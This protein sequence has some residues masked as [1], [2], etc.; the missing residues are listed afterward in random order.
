MRHNLPI[1]LTGPQSSGKL[2]MIEH[3]ASV[4]LKSESSRTD[5]SDSPTVT[6]QL[7]DHSSFD[8][9]SLIGSY[10]SSPR[11]PGTF[12]WVEG[13]LTRA[14]RSGKWLVLKDI[15]KATSEILSV[16]KPLVEALSD[17]KGIGCLP[18]LHLG[19]R[20]KVK[21]GK[22]FRLFATRSAQPT[23]KRHQGSQYPPANFRGSRHWVEVALPPLSDQDIAN[24]SSATFPD[25]ANDGHA[26]QN[27]HRL[28]EIFKSLQASTTVR[29]GKQPLAQNTGRGRYPTLRDLFKWF[30]RIERL[31]EISG[32]GMWSDQRKRDR[33]FVEAVEIF[34]GALP[35]TFSRSENRSDAETWVDSQPQLKALVT[36]FG[37]DSGR[38]YM[39]VFP[40]QSRLASKGK[41]DTLEDINGGSQPTALQVGRIELSRR[42]TQ[43]K[44]YNTSQVSRAFALTEPT[45][46]LLERIAACVS[47]SEPALLVGETGTGKTTTVQH[48]ASLLGHDVVALNLSQQSEASDLLGS[49]KPLEPRGPATELHNIWYDL[50]E[51]T[52]SAKRNANFVDS[53]R[54]ALQNAKWPRLVTLWKESIRMAK[55]R[56]EKK[57]RLAAETVQRYASPEDASLEATK[58]RRT[59]NGQQAT[60]VEQAAESSREAMLDENWSSFAARVSDF[61]A[62]HAS[63]KRNFVFNFVE[64]PLVKALRQGAWVLL[65]EINL[66]ASETLDSLSGMLSTPTASVTLFERGDIEPIPRHPDFRI[67][68]CM[69]PA[70]DVGKKDLPANLRNRFT[71]L[72]V[73]S[74]DS[75][76]AA[77]RAIVEQY[78]GHLATGP[79]NRSAPQDVAQCYVEIRQ[80]AIDR[81]ADGANQRP[82]Y[83]IRTLARAL[84]FAADQAHAFGLRRALWEGFVMAFTMLLQED[85]ATLIRQILTQQLLSRAGNAKQAA[86]TA[87]ARP[88]SR[89]GEDYVRVGPFWLSTGPEPIDMAE[90]Y[91]V[92][93]S[94]DVKLT[95]LARAILARN[96][97]V[98]IQGPTSAGKTSAIE[99]LARRTG[100]RFVRIN[101]HEHTD[102]QEYLGS[103]AS[104]QDTGRLVFH[105]GLLVKALRRGDWIVL[106]ELNLAPTDVLEALNR[107][108]DDNRELIIPETGEVVRPHPRFM[109]FA[110]QNPP[111]IYAGRK[112]LSRAFRNRFLELHFDDVPRREL[113]VI[114]KE[115]CQI[116]ESHAKKIVAVFEELQ[117][118][119]QTDRI[120]DTKQAFVTL[121][122]LF[123]WGQRGAVTY[124]ELA[125][126]GFM[127]IAERAR[128][129]SDRSVVKTVIEET[130]NERGSKRVKLNEHSLYDLRGAGRQAMA[131]R[132]GEERLQAMIT[133]CDEGG[134]VWTAAMSR[135]LCL[136]A[137]SLTHNEPVLLVGETGAGKT[138]ACEIVAKALGRQLYTVNCHQ[139]TETADLIGGQR[140]LRNRG[141]LQA[142]AKASSLA[143][144]RTATELRVDELEAESLD[145]LAAMLNT[146]IA[147]VKEQDHLQRLRDAQKLITQASALFEWRDG[148][149]VEAM[150]SGHHL[151]LDEISL[152]DDSV[153]ERLN[154]VLEPSRTL[155][156]AEKSGASTKSSGSLD[157]A[158]IQGADGFQ[159]VATMNPGGDYGKKELSPALRNRFTEIWV[160]QV[161]DH[162][163]ILAIFAAQWAGGQESLDVLGPK[164]LAFVDWFAIQLG[165]KDQAGTG[166]RDLVAW[167]K[168][169]KTC[170]ATQTLDSA[171][172]FVHGAL[173]AFI[174]GIG[175]MAA[176]TAMSPAGIQALRS[177]CLTK[178]HELAGSHSDS[179]GFY[180]TTPSVH[181]ETSS[182]GIGPF[183][184][185]TGPAS[186]VPS[187]SDFSFG[188]ATP[189]RNAL[190]VLRA[191][192]VPNKAVLLEG[193]PGAGKT[194]L[195]T[196][197][198]QAASYPLT[199][200]NLSDQTELV[201]LFGADLP[202]EGGG[203][204][205]FAWKDAAFLSAMQR[206]EWV[207]LDEMNL[208]S[209]SVLEGLNSCLDHRGSVY[210]PELGRTFEKHPDF[211]LFAAQNPH[212][213]GGG[214]KGLPKSFLNRFT[215]V[216]VDEL[217][218][219]DILAICSH[220]YPSYEPELLKKM[221]DFNARLHLE[222]M[223]KR[224]F[225]HQGAPWEFNLRDLLR[226]LKMIHSHLGLNWKR[227]PMEYLAVLY[228]QR[229]R[230]S[231][232]RAAAG[233]IFESVFDRSYDVNV[234]PWP[235]ITAHHAQFGHALLRRAVSL[236]D[237]STS[238]RMALLPSQL[239]ALEAL[240]D[241][242]QLQWLAILVGPSKCG[243]TSLVRLLARL[244]GAPLEE[245]RMNSGIDTMDVLGTFEQS[246]PGQN[247]RTALDGLLQVF[248]KGAASEALMAGSSRSS[249]FALDLISR[250]L[251]SVTTSQQLLDEVVHAV[252][253]A[254]TT[255]PAHAADQVAHLVNIVKSCSSQEQNAA[256]R[257]EWTDGPLV[258]A[259]REGSWLLVD[260]ANL[261][262]ASVLDRLNSLFEPDGRL[263]LSERG[264][265]DGHI[266]V[267]TPH[268]NFR[269]FMALDPQHGELSRA[270]RN[271]GLEISLSPLGAEDDLDRLE[272]ISSLEHSKVLGHNALP[273]L[274]EY[275]SLTRAQH[276][277]DL[278]SRGIDLD[279][280]VTQ[281]VAGA[282]TSLSVAAL[283]TRLAQG[284]QI[285]T[286]VQLYTLLHQIGAHQ[287]ALKIRREV[288]SEKSID[289]QFLADEAFCLFSNPQL[290]GDDGTQMHEL[291]AGLG[292]VI[293]SLSLSQLLAKVQKS[294][295]PAKGGSILQNWITSRHSPQGGASNDSE[296]DQFQQISALVSFIQALQATA[297]DQAF[298][299]LQRTGLV[300]LGSLLELCRYLVA[301]CADSSS[302]DYSVQETVV[303]RA[304]ELIASLDKADSRLITHWPGLTPQ[305]RALPT[306]HAMIPIWEGS[307]LTPAI[308]DGSKLRTRLLQALQSHDRRTPAP[309]MFEAAIDLIATLDLSNT[310]WT[311]QQQ[312]DF[313]A[314]ASRVEEQLASQNSTYLPHSDEEVQTWDAIYIA[315]LQLNLS[316]HDISND[317]CVQ[318]FF[319][320]LL[321]QISM[322]AIYPWQSAVTC[323]RLS[324]ML[325]AEESHQSLSLA[326]YFQWTQPLASAGHLD[327]LYQSSM[328]QMALFPSSASRISMAALLHHRAKATRMAKLV[329]AQRLTS[330]P[331]RKSNFR[332]ELLTFSAALL[333]ILRQRSDALTEAAQSSV[334][335]IEQSLERLQTTSSEDLLATSH[336][337]IDIAIEMLQLYLPNVPIDP[338]ALLRSDEALA[339]HHLNKWQQMQSLW[340]A[341]EKQHVGSAPTTQSLLQGI[342]DEV[343][344]SDLQWRAAQRNS[345]LERKPDLTR[346]ASFFA[347]MRA[348]SSQVLQPGDVRD[349]QLKL[350]EATG[351]NDQA[352]IREQ[353]LQKTLESLRRKLTVEYTDLADLCAPLEKVVDLFEVGFH[354]LAWSKSHSF[355]PLSQRRNESIVHALVQFPS[356]QANDKLYRTDL[357]VK[358]SSKGHSGALAVST[359]LT[360]LASITQDVQIGK[361]LASSLRTL[362]RTYDQLFFIWSRDREREQTAAEEQRSIYTSRNNVNSDAQNDD[363]AV[364][365]EFRSMFPEYEEDVM[366][367][368]ETSNS[369]LQDPYGKQRRSTNMMQRED[370]LQLAQLH[371]ALFSERTFTRLRTS[372]VSGLRLSL[373]R[374]MM[375]SSYGSATAEELDQNSAALQ[376]QILCH[377][378]GIGNAGNTEPEM[379]NFYLTASIF[380]TTKATNIVS[381][382]RT[383][384]QEL[385]QEWP[386]QMVLQHIRDR[387][388]AILRLDSASPIAKVLAALEQLLVHSE[389]WEGYAN[390]SNSLSSHRALITEQIVAWRRLELSSWASLLESQAREYANN[391]GDWWFRL[392]ELCVTG[393]QSSAADSSEKARAYLRSL[394]SLLD[395][396]VRTSTLGDFAARLQLLRSFATYI[397]ALVSHAPS[398]ETHGLAEVAQVLSNVG[399][400][401]GQFQ[402]KM[403]ETLSSQRAK[404]EK[405]IRDF[406]QLASWKDI[407]IHALKQSAQKSHRR[408]HKS[409]RQFRDV[410]KQPVDPIL[411]ASSEIKQGASDQ[412]AN[413][414]DA[415]T[416]PSSAPTFDRPAPN[417]EQV[418]SVLASDSIRSS[419]L[420]SHLQ[421]LVRTFEILAK[422]VSTEIPR[423]LASVHASALDEL[424][425]TIV[426]Q[427]QILSKATPSL[428][429]EKTQAA[430]KNL[431]NRKRKA[432]TDLLKELR[433]IGLTP[434]ANADMIA[435]NQD[436]YRLFSQPR[437][438]SSLYGDK[439][440]GQ[441][442]RLLAR[443]PR[444]RESIHRAQGDVPMAELIRGISYCEHAMSLVFAERKRMSAFASPQKLFL[445]RRRRLM[446]LVDRPDAL[447][448]SDDLVSALQ[449][450]A[451]LLDSAANALVEIL[452]VSTPYAQASPFKSP[453]LE[454][455]KAH[456][457]QIQADIL[458][459]SLR[460]KE[461]TASMD[462]VRGLYCLPEELRLIQ[463]T[464]EV[465]SQLQTELQQTARSLPALESV[466]I[467][468]HRWLQRQCE[469][470]RP[471][472]LAS[473]SMPTGSTEDADLM[474]VSCNDMISSVLLVAQN[475]GKSST[476][477]QD[478]DTLCDKAIQ[479]DFEKLSSLGQHLH[480][481]EMQAK[482]EQ[483][484]AF[485][486][487]T[488]NGLRQIRRVAPFVDSYCQM[489]NDHVEAAAHW[490]C[491]IQKLSLVLSST[492]AS[493]ALYGF[494]K[495]PEQDD[496][497]ASDAD[498]QGQ[499]LEGGTGLGDGSG[500]QDITDQLEDD[501]TVEELQKD[502]DADADQGA[503]TEREKNAREAGEDIDGDLDNVDAND[504]SD[505][506]QGETDAAEPEEQVGDV[507]PLDPSAVD[508][509]IWNGEQDDKEKQQDQGKDETN[510]DLSGEEGG[511]ED[512]AAK[513][514]GKSSDDSEAPQDSASERKD[515]QHEEDG[516]K[517][518]DEKERGDDEQADATDNDDK[519]IQAEDDPGREDEQQQQQPG[520]QLDDLVD[521]GENLDI[522][523]DLQM[524]EDEGQ[525]SDQRG[526]D[527]MS[528]M[529][530]PEDEAEQGQD[531]EPDSLNED[532]AE[533]EQERAMD[534]DKL[535]QSRPEQDDNS[536]NDQSDEAAEE[537]AKNDGEDAI[538]EKEET[539][540]DSENAKNKQSAD[541]ATD[542]PN[543]AQQ[544][545]ATEEPQP[546]GDSQPAGDSA[547]SADQQGASRGKQGRQS[548]PQ[549]EQSSKSQVEE[550]SQGEQKSGLEEHSMPADA[551]QQAA[552]SKA[553]QAAEEP[554]ANGREMTP[555]EDETEPTNPLRSL[556]D[557]LSEFRRNVDKIAEA[558][559]NTDQRDE[560]GQSMPE[561]SDV[562]HVANDEDAEMQAL[563]AA[564]KE[565]SSQKLPEKTVDGDDKEAEAK[566]AHED[567]ELNQD[568]VPTRDQRASLPPFEEQTEQAPQEDEGR[569]QQQAK[570][571]LPSDVQKNLQQR[572][573]GLDERS[574]DEETPEDISLSETAA[575]E[576][577]VDPLPDDEREVVDE[578]VQDALAEFRSSD[579][580]EDRLAKAGELWRSYTTL[581]SDLAFSL[582]E[583]LR[584]ILTPTLAARLNGDFRTGKR[585]NMRK[586]VPFIASD[587]AKDKIW[588]RRTKPS[589][590]EYQVLLAVDDS[591]SM[592][593]NRSVHLA[594]Q[595]LALVTSA[596][597]RL[598]VGDVSICRFGETVQTVLPFGGKGT[599]GDDSGAHVLDQLSFEQ[600]STNMV[601]LVE[602]TLDSLQSARDN[603]P[604]ASGSSAAELWQLEIIIS[605]GVCQERDFERLRALLR[606]AAEQ[607]VMIV[608]VIVDSVGA[609]SSA[610]TSVMSK[611]SISYEN[612]E[613]KM[614]RYMD[615]FPFSYY[616]VLREAEALPEVLATTLRQWAE[617]IREAE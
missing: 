419:T 253:N 600:R 536:D 337:F 126:N 43:P 490:H 61:S 453:G 212:Q 549:A 520:R 18:E 240:A 328:L 8:A 305:R 571:L 106:D 430:I 228:I 34:L 327:R 296:E 48:L 273:V 459:R 11:N 435:Q 367:S 615:K 524:S 456:V 351:I 555:Q 214:R 308:P 254:S 5:G 353:S 192:Y 283:A 56:S 42:Q 357:P 535:D 133:A 39:L 572:Q 568:V 604:S 66:A 204:G 219:D 37:L 522:G 213:Q 447:P 492:V 99:Y 163:D 269:L 582:C 29:S 142:Q 64:G 557:A 531:A 403:D 92:T 375:G 194:S 383:R 285:D 179:N 607:R 136:I 340:T 457:T 475:V 491:G 368:A 362:S 87:A 274:T 544:N 427:S 346:L 175:A 197:L 387:C 388:D 483:C 260:D 455:F 393:M 312:L 54:K 165:G 237:L 118:R 2:S 502:E 30:T 341:F 302:F 442:Y 221:I 426:E 565:D 251:R 539:K 186:D 488:P 173:L 63:K 349:L 334:S 65:D 257:F 286:L 472:L 157:S 83:S 589:K 508:E 36:A 467:P 82:H 566:A 326:E 614:D 325:L 85:S 588:L 94:V 466:C 247:V 265:V 174:D 220:L 355:A 424:A 311:P 303:K 601:R 196:A 389:D 561:S 172:A 16:I 205:E 107:L 225:G 496:S 392:F 379:N 49:F 412:V 208:T 22:T 429:T 281:N 60:S 564:E 489:L 548:R 438:H 270:M 292:I 384:L 550:Q 380:E 10:T 51:T 96:S 137:L 611:L 470:L 58:K 605:D 315:A 569:E 23:S 333:R 609:G 78:I 434:F 501:E 195:I 153:L 59:N 139:S 361:S 88:V 19:T 545:E 486:K 441:Y 593:E 198:A 185:P 510:K 209:Q 410:L 203:P 128:R 280:S 547:A 495:P 461:L 236:S 324:W 396:F 301:I 407:N 506:E 75:D 232:D 135:L 287:A 526:D 134:I 546:T 50:F 563:G 235:V 189:A 243:K 171:S 262:S 484:L 366:D 21:A 579:A 86:K 233:R 73:Q 105:E 299:S 138:S 552:G 509:K 72:Y 242:I 258:R 485:A 223:V 451:W 330:S 227:V 3:L 373:L 413:G 477:T 246:D 129:T 40:S 382:M 542:D 249:E 12:E 320:E 103:Y 541:E 255:L 405:D 532:F 264:V 422:K 6:L 404:I 97:P 190:K 517:D 151:L 132:I 144:L 408:L 69:N 363:E 465:L 150:R 364:E 603:Q 112:V 335:R 591:R 250:A 68:A 291:Q 57:K 471:R 343:A 385:I 402:P 507:D 425:C 226:W 329:S 307:L 52:F 339:L 108:L 44:L 95:G 359:L 560:K 267:V 290:C 504:G 278:C 156:L 202:V 268:P 415:Q 191:L 482:T 162:E 595:T 487:K 218:A 576:E 596:L 122:D 450:L 370:I 115:R 371:L 458:A 46:Q 516:G 109:L 460:I 505:E 15:D 512:S 231:N 76:F 437:L 511:N 377:E 476:L 222:T 256:G 183:K 67:F 401:Y 519:D 581:T 386:E 306:G 217:Q 433:R 127:L 261:C 154:S 114:L 164:I 159:V 31:S 224:S 297:A 336:A 91:V 124:Q 567:P 211:R 463:E 152:A 530:L 177:K 130:M 116:A 616:V 176:T 35:S 445:L 38:A 378:S 583:Q 160:P 331:S 169:I 193:S 423:V 503:E 468:T 439:I 356:T 80:L 417:M 117:R 248:R 140:P 266:Q 420:P 381:A 580:M 527:G 348:F 431:T 229:F 271:R 500:A 158:S 399:A 537:V 20:G 167:V 239:P 300:A 145:G 27:L 528:D 74:P 446:V 182:F 436:L 317:T 474:E 241:S 414:N 584:L 100:H 309:A 534:L 113:E 148:P 452:G 518:L 322:S 462:A 598:E 570:A 358:V 553:E 120:F 53:E 469:N 376:L 400:F 497:K 28:I 513:A 585:L 594:Y 443:L 613:M 525:Q 454:D 131:S 360:V 432:W 234:R 33:V 397:D 578:Q 84:T 316:R 523:D 288:S 352:F 184:I 216:Y 391:V 586:I 71:E 293:T 125:E 314:L 188:A 554:Q 199:R 181:R 416:V 313:R 55:E 558:D 533:P 9:K 481:F 394:V 90:D 207:L 473:D 282:T 210:I 146:A 345:S 354:S 289:D 32:P 161:E 200:I 298:S 606:R 245:M 70:T 602:S 365:A 25:L 104:D 514:E 617:K 121:R 284:Q 170:V 318:A 597:S 310:T 143:A 168:F 610:D 372:T 178:V 187:A 319:A 448:C 215:K 574:Q 587:F 321:R 543:L 275:T 77:L 276:C 295:V 390:T 411:A 272:G 149:L 304:Q 119:R 347:D 263:V 521:Q 332:A 540:P 494:C 406:V 1:L 538:E 323:R 612:G 24:I 592:A 259:M 111:G 294:A 369:S 573:A 141:A 101:N 342:G 244:V 599:F 449:E 252:S 230:N 13:A 147:K 7:G 395:E 529:E 478:G 421:D 123:R 155:V 551:P 577:Q 45:Q 398:K 110:T 41:R 590:R 464:I 238:Q 444:L 374:Q 498:G 277:V 47:A 93:P 559:S 201:D 515:R 409:M 608:F 26:G 350:S 344:R 499:D 180:G 14:V 81:L 493:L 562:E 440:D 556:G 338:L 17:F 98:L 4:L 89:N 62:Q 418:T 79:Q 166:L 575:E 480:L 206:G 102:I 428:A 479:L 279:R